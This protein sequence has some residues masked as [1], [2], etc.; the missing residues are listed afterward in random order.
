MPHSENTPKQYIDP[1]ALSAFRDAFGI[2]AKRT[3]SFLK[4]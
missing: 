2:N 3:E 4:I 1:K